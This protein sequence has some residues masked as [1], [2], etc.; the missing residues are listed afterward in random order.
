[1]YFYFIFVRTLHYWNKT[2]IKVLCTDHAITT[3]KVFNLYYQNKMYYRYYIN[4][5]QYCIIYYYYRYIVYIILYTIP[6]ACTIKII[7][8]DHIIMILI[9]NIYL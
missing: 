1:M 4:I 7:I 2:K 6:V 5:L 3:V 9:N 8:T